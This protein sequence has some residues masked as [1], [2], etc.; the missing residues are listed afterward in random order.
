MIKVEIDKKAN[1]FVDD[2]AKTN[3]EA[4]VKIANFLSETLP[5]YSGDLYAKCQIF[6]RLQR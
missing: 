4:N 6:K 2:L 5:N 3:K 1:K